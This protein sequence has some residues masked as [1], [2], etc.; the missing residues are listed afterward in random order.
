MLT[1]KLPGKRL[2]RRNCGVDVPSVFYYYP[3]ARASL[4]IGRDDPS[5]P[6]RCRISLSEDRSRRAPIALWWGT[7]AGESITG[8]WVLST[9]L[10]RS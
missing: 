10:M 4:R 7:Q 8:L 5:A 2:D 6:C 1:A 9:D 3:L